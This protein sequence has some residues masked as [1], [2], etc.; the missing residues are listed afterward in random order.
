MNNEKQKEA[1]ASVGIPTNLPPPT[2]EPS[3]IVGI[4]PPSNLNPP[5]HNP[6]S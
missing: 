2:D 6:T 1:E 3:P 5:V 4:N